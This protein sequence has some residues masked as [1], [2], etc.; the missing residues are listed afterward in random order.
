M[1]Y[2]FSDEQQQFRGVVQRFMRD[3]SP[4]T[5][6]R[7]LMATKDGFDRDLW[8]Q[9]C[10]D[11]GLAGLHV[12]EAYGGSGFGFVEVGIDVEA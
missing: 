10:D 12:P 2:S 11:L 6:V 1:E 8:M 7:R 3:K 5:E 4:M 9:S